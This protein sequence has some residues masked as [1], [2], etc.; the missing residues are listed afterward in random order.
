MAKFKGF[1]GSSYRLYNTSYAVERTLN[2]FPAADEVQLGKGAEVA[3]L[4]R[5]PGLTLLAEIPIINIAGFIYT[6]EGGVVT[7]TDT[8]VGCPDATHTVLWDFGDGS[9]STELNPVHTY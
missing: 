4:E 1:V 8:S 2:L 3:Q 6:R 5:T 7:F 9:T